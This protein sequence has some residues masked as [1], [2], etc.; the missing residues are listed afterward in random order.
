MA[1]V[2]VSIKFNIGGG[3]ATLVDDLLIQ[4]YRQLSMLDISQAAIE[5]AKQR[6]GT[7]AA[8]V[9]WLAA[10]ILHKLLPELQTYASLT[11][12]PPRDATVSARHMPRP[13]RPRD[14]LLRLG[15]RSAMLEP[16][17]PRKRYAVSLA[18]IDCT[19]FQE[20]CHGDA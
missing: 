3:E 9:T 7:H 5:V 8:H 15:S 20:C 14:R 12:V 6:L 19:L 1:L 17:R 13:F 18:S 4:G 11:L 10:D 16:L 2:V